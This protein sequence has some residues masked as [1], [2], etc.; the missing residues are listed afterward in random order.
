MTR[1]IV[2][3]LGLV[4]VFQALFALCLVSAQQ[5]LVPRHALGVVGPPSPVVA[6]VASGRLIC[7]P[8]RASPRR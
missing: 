4:L 7:L 1:K 3:A 2:I 5:L 8:S 6:A